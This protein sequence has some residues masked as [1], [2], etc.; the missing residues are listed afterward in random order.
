[1]KKRLLDVVCR[2][3]RQQHLKNSEGNK[4][5]H[6]VTVQ[7]NVSV[8]NLSKLQVTEHRLSQEIHFLR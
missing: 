4:V 5:T 1:M 8:F 2:E 7:Q 6:L 3:G